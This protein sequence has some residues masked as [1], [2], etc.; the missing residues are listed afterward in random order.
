M[1]TT[2]HV[3]PIGINDIW[4]EEYDKGGNEESVDHGM[5]NWELSSRT[6]CKCSPI[7]EEGGNHPFMLVQGWYCLCRTKTSI[8]S[9]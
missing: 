2:T 6:M 9:D 1:L 5:Q 8:W 3:I 7:D 4:A